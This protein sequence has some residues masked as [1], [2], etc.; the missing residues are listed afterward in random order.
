MLDFAR[1]SL[2][3]GLLAASAASADPLAGTKTVTLMAPDGSRLAVGRVRFEPDGDASRY[4]L[5]WDEAAFE[6]HFLSM[7]PFRCLAGPDKHWC[8]VPYPYDIRR[9]VDA[10][11]L[12]DL[13]YDMLFVWKGA[14][15]YGIN[16]WNGVYY[17]LEI[18]GDRIVGRMREIDM[19]ILSAPPAAG[20]L[21]PLRPGD[22]HET[23][24]ESHWLPIVVIE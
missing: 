5:S 11:D 18:D 10:Q 19:D 22:L 23:D 3:A 7:R 21:R 9:R 14:G 12:R 13:E 2:V 8:Q 16:M 4:A 24:P 20:D 1:F 17:V 6:D 15:D